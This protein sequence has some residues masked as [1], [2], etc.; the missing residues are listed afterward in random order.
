MSGQNHEMRGGAAPLP[1]DPNAQGGGRDGLPAA[2]Q[3]MHAPVTPGRSGEQRGGGPR[4]WDSPAASQNTAGV[5][6]SLPAAASLAVP[7][8]AAANCAAG[9]SASAAAFSVEPT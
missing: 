7:H 3:Q 4:S 5:S 9:A 1:P 6:R 8:P 2:S